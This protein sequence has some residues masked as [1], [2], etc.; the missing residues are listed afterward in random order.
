MTGEM[1]AAISALVSAVV[2]GV[3]GSLA[4]GLCGI[5]T[6]HLKEISEWANNLILRIRMIRDN[7]CDYWEKPPRDTALRD[8]ERKILDD[9]RDLD[10]D[11][12]RLADLPRVTELNFKRELRKFWEAATADPFG[13]ISRAADPARCEE[14]KDA[15]DNLIE[16][17]DN[18]EV[19]AHWLIKPL[20]I[21][22]RSS[23]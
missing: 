11:L 17:I 21:K 4:G 22:P 8:F 16:A 20:L 18:L 6:T 19:R 7:S 2:G 13:K 15:A 14:A 1:V 9:L 3:C 12:T 10:Q 23:R 5:Y